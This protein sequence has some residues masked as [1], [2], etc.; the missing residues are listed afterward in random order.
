MA[1]VCLPSS[2][3]TAACP[4]NVNVM[5]IPVLR[6]RTRGKCTT[7]LRPSP[8]NPTHDQA[9]C[10]VGRQP[11]DARVSRPGVGGAGSGR[12]GAVRAPGAGRVPGGLELVAH[13]QATGTSPPGVCRIRPR[14]PGALY[15]AAGGAAAPGSPHHPQPAQGAGG[16][17]QCAGVPRPDGAAGVV[18]P[19]PVGVRG[20]QP[21]AEPLAH[22]EAATAG[23]QG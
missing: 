23:D 15:A 13:P 21:P 3:R 19:V 11:P 10:V 1:T 6:L 20:E 12:P 2:S 22:I 14:A 4:R 16:G 8:G 17:D 9:L 18:Q 7:L 5:L